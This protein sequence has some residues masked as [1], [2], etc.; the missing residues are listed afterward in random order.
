MQL[1]LPLCLSLPIP[2][3]PPLPQ[4]RKPIRHRP[5]T[6]R[7]RLHAPRQ[8]LQ[9]LGPP[10]GI[11]ASILP[12]PQRDI[13]EL[14][15]IFRLHQGNSLGELVEV[16]Q[17]DGVVE[18]RHKVNKVGDVEGQGGDAVRVDA[19]DGRGE[20]QRE[21]H[22]GCVGEGVEVD[23]FFDLGG[24]AEEHAGHDVGEVAC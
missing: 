19:L 4:R 14:L 16:L 7:L 22:V 9:H 13:I 6:R 2:H 5:P 12:I 24:E 23:E 20:G 10:H 11:H 21:D 1:S 15:A 18:A 17:E 8:L 3:P